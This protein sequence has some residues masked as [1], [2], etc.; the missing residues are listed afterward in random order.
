MPTDIL[1]MLSQHLSRLIE[2]VISSA[3]QDNLI[4]VSC[5]CMLHVGTSQQLL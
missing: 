2:P 3:V 1:V 4:S 5:V